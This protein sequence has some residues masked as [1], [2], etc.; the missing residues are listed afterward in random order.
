MKLRAFACWLLLVLLCARGYADERPVIVLIAN[1][2]GSK[3][4]GTKP[5]P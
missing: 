2:L 4:H 5:N 3:L 1:D